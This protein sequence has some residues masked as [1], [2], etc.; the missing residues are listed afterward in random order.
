MLII[1][2]KQYIPTFDLIQ[3]KM[4]RIVESRAKKIKGW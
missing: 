4:I 1:L 3:Y 2:L